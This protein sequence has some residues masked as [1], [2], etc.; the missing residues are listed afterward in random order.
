MG[1]Y[2]QIRC[3]QCQKPL[4]H[5][6]IGL[7]RR[8]VNRGAQECLCLECLA[9]AYGVTQEQLRKKIKF[10]KELGCCLF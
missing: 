1:E 4:T 5:D 9:R 7:F 6:E 2:R 3:Y 8:L 10:F